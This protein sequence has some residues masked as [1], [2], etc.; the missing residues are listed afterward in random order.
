MDLFVIWI[1]ARIKFFIYDACDMYFIILSTPNNI[2][3]SWTYSIDKL[4]Y[5]GKQIKVNQDNVA[6]Y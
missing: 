3:T 1:I 2:K 5:L 4:I 6:H